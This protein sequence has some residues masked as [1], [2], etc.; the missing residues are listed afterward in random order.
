MTWYFASVR[1]IVVDCSPSASM[2]AKGRGKE[3]ELKRRGAERGDKGI[4]GTQGT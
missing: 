2:K 3:R 4:R 1:V